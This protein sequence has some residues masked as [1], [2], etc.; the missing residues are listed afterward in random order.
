M[1]TTESSRLFDVISNADDDNTYFTNAKID[2]L[3]DNFLQVKRIDDN[4]DM[5]AKE[6]VLLTNITNK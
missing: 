1:F 2:N 3:R 4:A 5:Y 6:L